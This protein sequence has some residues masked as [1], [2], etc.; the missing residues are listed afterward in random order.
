MNRNGVNFRLPL[1]FPNKPPYNTTYH[2][3]TN[4]SIDED[5]RRSYRL[6]ERGAYAESFLTRMAF[7]PP[8]NCGRETFAWT[9]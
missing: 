6:S 1:D 5:T 7:L 4:K 9:I 8:L 3:Q 2:S